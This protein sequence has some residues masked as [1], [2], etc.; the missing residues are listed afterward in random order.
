MLSVLSLT[1]RAGAGYASLPVGADFETSLLN[2]N[3]WTLQGTWGLSTETAH[4]GTNCLTDSPQG[5]YGPST[6][7]SAILGVDLRRATRPFLSFW[8]SYA[9]EPNRDY[10][11]VELSTDQG[12]NWTR[13][14]A[15]TGWGGTNWYPVRLDLANYAGAQV[16]IRFRLRTDGQYQ[17]DGWYL[18]DVQVKDNDVRLA[19]PFYDG[20][21]TAASAT[22]WLA[23]GWRQVLGSAQTTAGQSW[24]NAVGDGWQPGLDLYASLTLA[25]TVDLSGAVAPRLSCWWRAGSQEGNYFYIQ[26]S[27]DGGKN[28]GNIWSWDSHW[29]RS[30]GW[31]RLQLDLSAY[32]GAPEF[33]LRFLGY[34]RPDRQFHMDFQVDDIVLAEAPPDVAVTAAPGSDPRHSAL[35]SWAPSTAPGFAYYGLFRSTSPGVGPGNFLVATLTNRATVSFEDTGLDVCGQTYY[36]RVLIWNTN[37]LNNWGQDVSYRTRWGQLAT[38][39][40]VEGFENGNSYWA[41]DRP[42]GFGTNQSHGG[43]Q[44]LTDSPEGQYGNSV[45]AAA[46]VQVDLRGAA[47]PLLTFWEA[48]SLEA[49][50]DYGLVEM[51]SDD[52]AS[53]SRLSALTGFAEWQRQQIDLTPWAGNQLL[54]RFRLKTSGSWQDDGWSLDDLVIQENPARATYPFYDTMDGPST[55]TNWLVAGPWYRTGGSAETNAG[56]SWACGVGDGWQPGID[57]SSLLTLA[58]TIDLSGAVKPRLWFWWRAGS[59]EGNYFYAQ[60][61]ADGGKNWG[62]L[63]S[64]DSH[65]GRSSGWTRIQADLTGY[66]GATNLALRFD[67]YN[68]PDRQFRLD[69]Q[70]DDVLVDEAPDLPAELAVTIGPGTDPRHS[71][72]LNWDQATVPEFA[73][74][75]IY[76][77][78]SPGV[79]LGSPLLTTLSNRAT[80]S[81]EDTTLDVCGQTYYYRVLVWATNAL[82]DWVHN[83]GAQDV[84]YRTR[85]GQMVTNIPFAEGFEAGDAHWALD[86]PWGLTTNLSH[87]GGFCL[88]DSPTGEYGA[89]VDAAATLPLDLRGTSRPCLSYWQRYSLQANRDYGMVEFSTDDGA[90]WSRYAALTGFA[91]WHN[92]RIDLTPFSGTQVL[93]RF[94]L[95][96]D[97]SAQ[98]DGWYLDDIAIQENTAAFEYPF[99][100][101]M[102]PEQSQTNWLAAGPWS[103]WG[104]SAQTNAGQ[105]WG[106]GL[107]DRWQ[108][109]IDLNNM[110]TLA[111]T[112]DLST[113]LKPR[114]SFW[115]R[116]GSQEGNYFYTQ[117]SA[118]GGKNWGTLWSWDSHWG[119]SS[120]WTRVELDLT[121][122]L[123][124]TNLAVRFYAYNR[125]DR[126]F[127]LDFQIDD[128]SIAET[129][130]APPEVAATIEPGADP[131]HNAILRWQPSNLKEFAC[132]T[133]YRSTSPGVSASSYQ[134]T[135]ISNK[136]TLAFEDTTLDVCGQ[137][138]YYRVLV[139]NLSGLH[140]SGAN[141]LA[142]RTRWGQTVPGLPF[143]L[144]LENGDAFWAMDRPWGLTTNLS[145]TGLYCLADSPDG[146]YGNGVDSSATLRVDLRGTS[147]PYLSFWH[148]YS[149]QANRDYGFIELSSD[150]GGNWYRYAALTGFAEWEN[151]Q[152]DLTPWAGNQLLIRFR[153]KTDGSWQDDGWY[154]DDLVLQENRT[155]AG[156][157]FYDDMDAD[158]SPTNWLA[159]GPWRHVGGSTQG[160]PGRSYGCGVGDGWQPGVDLY[161]MLTLAG[162]VDLG[163]AVRPRLWFWWRAGS[164][165]GN[166][167]Y[168]Q[169]SPD[170]GKNW[171]TPWGWDSHWGRSSGWTRLEIDLSGYIGATNLA[172]RF[173]AYNR[174]DRQ[175]RLDFQIDEVLI[176][177]AAGEFAASIGPGVD[178]KHSAL[179]SWSASTAR[180]FA[181]YGL[182]RST[183]PGVGE[184]DTLVAMVTNRNTLSF[185]DTGLDMCGQTY[186]YKLLVWYTHAIHSQNTNELVYRTRWGQMVAGLPFAERFETGSEYWALDRPW[187]VTTE[188][189]HGG[190]QALSDSPGG[191][192]QTNTDRA[193]T[194]RVDLRRAARPLLSFWHRYSLEQDQDYGFVE[195]SGNDG[196]SWTT[197]AAVTGYGGWEN[198]RVDLTP[199]A[200]METLIRFRLKA[201]AQN[202]DDGWYLDD[203]EIRENSAVVAY[204]FYDGM[205]R[206]S[207]R[208]DW[209]AASWTQVGG[210]AQDQPG[211][212]WRCRL[213]DGL[214]AGSNYFGLSLYSSL[215]LAGT[216]DLRQATRPQLWFWWRTGQQWYHTLSAQVSPDGG[217][218]WDTVWTIN[219]L[220][221]GASSWLEVQADLSTYVGLSQVALRFLA[222]NPAAT[223]LRLD[224]Q[225]D[226]VLVGERD[227]PTILTAA[228]LPEGTVGVSYHQ[229]LQARHGSTPYGWT[230]LSN[231]LPPGLVLNPVE[232]VLSGTP[233]TPGNFDFWVRATDG[234][235]CPAQKELTLTVLAVPAPLA[236]QTSQPFV[237]PGT[238]VVFCE[239]ENPSP[240]R[241][242]ALAWSP[243]LPAGWS[244]L[245]VRGDGEPQLGLDGKILFQ[246]HSLS[247]ATLRFQY[248]VRIPPRQMQGAVIG[249]SIS[250]LFEGMANEGN[251]PASPELLSVSPRQYHSADCSQDWVIS[252]PEVNRV[253]AYW[254]AG[255]YRLDAWT[256]D[257]YA[258]GQGDR[259]GPLH[260]ADYAAPFWQLDGTEVNRVLSYWRA[261]CYHADTNGVD[262]YASGCA[263]PGTLSRVAQAGPW[264]YLSGG[265]ATI[266]NTVEYAGSLLSL[267][268]RPHLPAGWTLRSAAGSGNPEL[269]NGEIVWT[270]GNLPPSPI[271]LVYTVQIPAG[272]RGAQDIRGEVSFFAQNMVNAAT[273]YAEPDPITL[274]EAAPV[275]FLSI[276]RQP[277]GA[278]QLELEGVSAQPIR[279][280]CAPTVP[281]ATWTTLTEWPTLPGATQ[282]L[283]TSA[284][285]APQRFYRTI[286]P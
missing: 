132:Y 54:L 43:I 79:G 196:A 148:R 263:T 241:L 113:A 240:L 28:W 52:G 146:L 44:A 40:F 210:S 134:V 56:Y 88:A 74:Y 164:Q 14:C 69:F 49:N 280:Q 121:G 29:G 5:N 182:Y 256:C 160:G 75:A 285:N 51:S 34:N 283:D 239:V 137:T 36:Y 24:Q 170:G 9:L 200:G 33:T 20:N 157:P 139:W 109:G 85:W 67:G 243:T 207:S 42:W 76:R 228:P 66:L 32:V 142:Y 130:E 165:E 212:S 270:A 197:W 284:T 188:A 127:Y 282:Y 205:D 35:L 217:K 252:T 111:G 145:H 60:V 82:H 178:P 166:Y 238:N 117:V 249:G 180:D 244:I 152:L 231:T 237:S 265:T 81:F 248:V 91:E 213:G 215:T 264:A 250:Y 235:N 229:T 12:A 38:L 3:Y 214:R 83:W 37:Q 234:V 15:F 122:Y 185:E 277:D 206:A 242:L 100:D 143:T 11:L 211:Q 126:Q 266:T 23:A 216:L 98:D 124:V 10:A 246:E 279:L 103:Q 106:C 144:G 57:V 63:W 276:T 65:W 94:R 90:S 59:Q 99:R 27:T 233:T 26:A 189:A 114:L 175:F 193:A 198:Q 258:P 220:D 255:A 97:G 156:Y 8:Q 186:Y 120:G 7:S 80:V 21:D 224:F 251:A 62:T 128:V 150:D 184:A 1:S 17:Y 278:V 172:L 259:V 136:S 140:N 46:T 177:E 202:P 89:S 225:L 2:T 77:S 50:R 6:D 176:D 153:L 171:G 158:T 53:W 48:H 272:T 108:P 141:E 84:A 93:L 203:V 174:S 96:T 47:R 232:G 118:D 112:L 236:T 25:G 135:T 78:T 227:C 161:S 22:N 271:T 221:A 147:R 169:A 107:G 261:G 104:G 125:P 16:Q 162:T 138:Y 260:S 87:G 204:P 131:R 190:I 13:A 254:R 209:L 41:L 167:F 173:Y 268:W 101:N 151:Q 39:P 102:D 281:S 219:T 55:L 45:D 4:G 181:Y 71:A 226:Q 61:S 208:A 116:A 73:Y 30:A 19:Y 267:L 115:W 86:R 154:L 187:S 273:V 129:P 105:S 58:G 72:V 218:N 195:I 199:Y 110:L 183:R 245:E 18:D 155:K 92:Q 163:H 119:R 123:G 179:I 64:W 31:Q 247:N 222:D 68:R 286:S 262:G 149:L 191:A 274:N 269:V 257:G 230:V 253:L 159:V 168:V 133:I 70:V 275:R 223:P 192:Y 194:L 201:D 95:K